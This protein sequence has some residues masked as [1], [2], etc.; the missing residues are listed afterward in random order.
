MPA[1]P[2]HPDRFLRTLRVVRSGAFLAGFLAWGSFAFP[3]VT[4]VDPPSS[5]AADTGSASSGYA[6]RNAVS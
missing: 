5:R 6:V 4:A 1:R 2:W 3:T